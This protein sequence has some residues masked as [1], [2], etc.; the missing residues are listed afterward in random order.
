MSNCKDCEPTDFH[1]MLCSEHGFMCADK[2]AGRECPIDKNKNKQKFV[3]ENLEAQENTILRNLVKSLLVSEY[4]E[5]GD[6]GSGLSV[7]VPLDQFIQVTPYNLEINADEE[8]I[9]IK[10]TK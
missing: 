7:A 4:T 2:Q 10:L 1:P 9:E 6:I 8:I 5:N 3:D